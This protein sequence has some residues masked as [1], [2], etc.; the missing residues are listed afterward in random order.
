MSAEDTRLLVCW[1]PTAMPNGPAIGD[2]ERTTWGEFCGAFWWRREGDKDGPNFVPAT[3]T[4]EPDGRRVR[5]LKRNLLSRT[6][7]ALDCECNKET[8]E[9]PPTLSELE[10][11]IRNHGRAALVYTSHNHTAAAPRYRI[12]LP[13]SKAIETDLPAVEVIASDLELLGV[14]D[15]S[16]LGAS[17]LFYLPSAE[18]GRLDDHEIRVIDGYPVHAE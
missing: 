2:L 17:S 9:L 16:K 14:L 13:L 11:R 12:V 4:L 3:F 1:F 7:I 5:R 15:R 10:A 18:P 8:G 6:A